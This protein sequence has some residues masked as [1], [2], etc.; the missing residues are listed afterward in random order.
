MANT[1]LPD[2]LCCGNCGLPLVELERLEAYWDFEARTA[3]CDP[4]RLVERRKECAKAGH[5]RVHKSM[6]AGECENLQCFC[7]ATKHVHVRMT[8]IQMG[9]FT[10][11]VVQQ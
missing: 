6:A 9:E 10:W 7:G 8:A 4:C 3:L 1:L 11:P 5:H 2:G